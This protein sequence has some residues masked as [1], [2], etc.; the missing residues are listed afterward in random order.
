MGIFEDS[1]FFNY[2]T[3]EK[4]LAFVLKMEMIERWK[5]LSVEKGAK[6]FRELLVSLKEGVNF[7]EKEA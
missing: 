6:I 1:T 7:E 4:V 3:V 5:L 2:F